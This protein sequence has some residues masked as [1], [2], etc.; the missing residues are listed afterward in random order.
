[1][2]KYCG[3]ILFALNWFDDPRLLLEI[4]RIYRENNIEPPEKLKQRL[5][6]IG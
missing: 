5:I 2:F 6:E 3:D 1:M 4:I